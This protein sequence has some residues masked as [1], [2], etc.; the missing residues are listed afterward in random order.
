LT[1]GM[2]GI[3][4]LVAEKKRFSRDQVQKIINKVFLMVHR[5][6]FLVAPG[7]LPHVASKTCVNRNFDMSPSFL[8]QPSYNNHA[9]VETEISTCVLSDFVFCSRKYLRP[10][11]YFQC[12]VHHFPRYSFWY[13]LFILLIFIF[14][15]HLN[16]LSFSFLFLTSLSVFI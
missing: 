8:L 15:F 9:S 14:E 13:F 5:S 12:F 1:L 16:S 4:P 7:Q 10:V 3:R 11:Y 6:R 2:G